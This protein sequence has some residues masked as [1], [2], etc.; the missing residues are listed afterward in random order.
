[1]WF[2]VT[3]DIKP[4][5]PNPSKALR[6][7]QSL[8]AACFSSFMP[9]SCSK[10]EH[11]SDKTAH[12]P[13]RSLR[14]SSW[15]TTRTTQYSITNSRNQIPKAPY[16]LPQRCGYSGIEG[17]NSLRLLRL[18]SSFLHSSHRVI[19]SPT[20]KAP[21]V[22]VGHH[23]RDPRNFVWPQFVNTWHRLSRHAEFPSMWRW[24]K[25]SNIVSWAP[26]N[27]TKC[28]SEG[29]NDGD[30][31]WLLYYLGHVFDVFGRVAD[32]GCCFMTCRPGR[33]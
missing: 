22:H 18:T 6:S 15:Q 30:P 31:W 8:Q 28:I 16:C 10:S 14:V 7:F 9:S 2:T 3:R 26:P 11:N 4:Q 5:T 27:A 25:L 33:S 19:S 20:S 23:G 21:D 32:A 12:V 13:P 1:M 24:I 29:M 17:V